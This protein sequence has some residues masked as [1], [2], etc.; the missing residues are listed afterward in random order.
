MDRWLNVKGIGWIIVDGT[1]EK[2]LYYSST[3][4]TY[5]N[6]DENNEDTR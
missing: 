2:V 5:A 6:L 4:P 3:I 1:R